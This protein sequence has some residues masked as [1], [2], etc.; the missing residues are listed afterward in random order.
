MEHL[1][2]CPLCKNSA[3]EP[4][5]NARDYFLTSEPFTIVRCLSCHFLFTSPR[6]EK[7][8]IEKY[9]KSE[10]YISH[11]DSKRG[12]VNK[13]Y[14]AVRNRTLNEKATWI[15][16]HKK[17]GRV[18]DVGAGT[19]HFLHTMTKKGYSVAGVE[20]EEDARKVAKK[21]FDLILYN[22]IKSLPN[23]EKRFDVITLWHVLE[24]VH[25]L[26]ATLNKIRSLM[27]DQGILVVAVPNP[28]SY[29]ARY[30]GK[31]WAAYDLP[32]HLYHFTQDTI[33]KFLKPYGFEL[34]RSYPMKFDSY[35]VSMLSEK[36]RSGKTKYFNAAQRGFLSNFYARGKRLNYSSLTYIFT[37]KN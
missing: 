27:A 20:P 12:L 19:G 29:D 10:S 21:R 9:Y 35:Y 5:L 37:T 26:D 24:H 28:Q 13:I 18:L 34:T 31:Y 7:K 32:R 1:S 4:H 11:S 8:E 36:Y 23:Q 6:P 25:E 3:F 30:Y 33:T 17:Q 16:G 22:D 2:T 15:A 14:Q